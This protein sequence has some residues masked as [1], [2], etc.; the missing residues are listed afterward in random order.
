MSTLSGT[1]LHEPVGGDPDGYVE[2]FEGE[3]PASESWA[4]RIRP[5]NV[6]LCFNEAGESLIMGEGDTR[7]FLRPQSLSLFTVGWRTPPVATRIGPGF[8]RFV[9]LS[10]P[11]ERLAGFFGGGLANLH[12][13]FRAY[14]EGSGCGCFGVVRPMWGDEKRLVAW[15]QEPPVSK[16]ARELWYRSKI[17]ELLAIHLFAAGREPFCVQQWRR[18]NRFAD[19]AL[20]YLAEHYEEPL[21]LK[22]LA[23]TC[24]CSGSYLSRTVKRETGKTLL[25]HL[26]VIRVDAAA[27]LMSNG[28]NVTEAAFAVGYSSLSHFS[29]AFAAE[30]GVLPSQFIRPASPPLMDGDRAGDR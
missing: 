23:A 3:L 16:E 28:A 1:V 5:N 27:R 12:P 7:L 25:R 2:R 9:V 19:Q 14:L 20:V 26:R 22:A 4:E 15:L 18:A 24:G 13:D 10:V 11:R 29:K 30:K 6:C 17:G 8:Q 21:D